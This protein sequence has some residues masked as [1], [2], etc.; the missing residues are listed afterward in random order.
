MTS[1]FLSFFLKSIEQVEIGSVEFW[2]SVRGTFPSAYF[3]LLLFQSEGWSG[4]VWDEWQ[5]TNSHCCQGINHRH[6]GKLLLGVVG[7]EAQSRRRGNR[8][9]YGSLARATDT[10]FLSSLGFPKWPTAGRH[11]FPAYLSREL[12]KVGSYNMDRPREDSM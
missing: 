4:E 12:L 3:L 5:F 11:L 8:R 6:C 7:W 1:F 9:G 10:H 2:A